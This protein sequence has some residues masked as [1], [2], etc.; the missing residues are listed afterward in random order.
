MAFAAIRRIAAL[1]CLGAVVALAAILA[2][3]HVSHGEG[4]TLLHREDL[5]MAVIALQT[6]VCMSLAVKHDFACAATRELY[7]LSGRHRQSAAYECHDHQ[8]YHC[9]YGLLHLHFLLNC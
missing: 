3:V 6:F 1:E 9:Q 4:T 7:R 5:G 8:N 2:C